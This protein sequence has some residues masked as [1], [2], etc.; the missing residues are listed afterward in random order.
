MADTAAYVEVGT[1]G[2]HTV[3]GT[4]RSYPS[5]HGETSEKGSA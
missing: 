5:S 2:W 1:L 3:G 4:K